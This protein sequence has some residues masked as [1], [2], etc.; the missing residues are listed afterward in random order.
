V[1]LDFNWR[2]LVPLVGVSFEIVFKYVWSV[3]SYNFKNNYVLP[4]QLGVQVEVELRRDGNGVE[5][6]LN[7]ADLLVVNNVFDV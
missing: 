4:H 5:D 6:R 1:V 2:L 7:V 3:V